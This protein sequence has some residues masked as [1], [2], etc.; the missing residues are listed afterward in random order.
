[1]I[2]KL[3]LLA[4]DLEQLQPW[5]EDIPNNVLTNQHPRYISKAGDYPSVS[6]GSPQ[7][8]LFGSVAS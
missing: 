7:C 8:M 3:N 2:G 5:I 1:M 6:R 4:D